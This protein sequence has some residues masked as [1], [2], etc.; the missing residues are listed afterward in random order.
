MSKI[1]LPA[2]SSTDTTVVICKNDMMLDEPTFR[3]KI[4][5]SDPL[6]VMNIAN[7]AIQDDICAAL[8]NNLFEHQ[9]LNNIKHSKMRQYQKIKLHQCLYI[10]HLHFKYL[11]LVHPFMEVNLIILVGHI[12]NQ[13]QI[14]E[15]WI[16]SK[17]C[18]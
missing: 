3:Q 1:T 14:N 5:R 6:L 4:Q 9:S 15:Y 12:L 11:L 10:Y 2:I 7:I 17:I 8:K 18:E 16:I 13:N